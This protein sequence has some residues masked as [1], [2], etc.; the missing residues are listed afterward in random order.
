MASSSQHLRMNVKMIRDRDRKKSRDLI[1]FFLVSLALLIPV[2]LYVRQRM[3]FMRVSYRL[4]EL[5]KERKSLQDM[6]RK[7]LVERAQ[8]NALD[9]VERIALEDLG[10]VANHPCEILTSWNSAKPADDREQGL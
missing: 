7:L 5:S 6:N 1:V 10:L 8:L 4:E 2:I 9:R 3:E